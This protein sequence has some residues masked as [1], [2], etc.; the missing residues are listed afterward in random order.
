MTRKL[1]LESALIF[2]SVALVLAWVIYQFQANLLNALL[3][4]LR[5]ALKLLM[6]E[7]RVDSL[8]WKID[9]NET[10]LALTATLTEYRV[11]L[12][13][14]L[15]SG[16][17][18][19]AV[20]LAAHAW[21][22]PVL[23]FSL[24]AAWP[25]IAWRRKAILILATLPLVLLAILLDIPLMLWGAVEDF[26]YWQADASRVAESWGSRVQHFLDG[27][28]RYALS[29]LLTLMTIYLFKKLNFA[30]TIL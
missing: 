26:L 11:I 8:D 20:T 18:V 30:R 15:P 28:G 21:I 7:F 3:P 2:L 23:M 17:T 6:P 16:A 13:R 9:R 14:V 22:H 1:L 12:G 25:H 27:G 10:V 4:L 19:H 29:I 5:A 24:I